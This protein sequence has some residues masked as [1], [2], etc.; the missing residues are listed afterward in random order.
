MQQGAAPI[1]TDVVVV[2]A[3]PVGL[4]QVFQL[5]LLEMRAEVVD[6]LPYVG[7]QCIELYADK[8]IYDIPGLPYCTGR[9]L[10]QRLQQ[11]ITP[12]KTTFHLGQE[13]RELRE[14]DTAD[15][16]TGG[17]RFALSTSQG[18]QFRCKAVIVAGGV[19]SFQ[20]RGLK[21]PGLEPFSGTQMRYDAH[22]TAALAGQHVVVAGDGDVAVDLALQLAQQTHDGPASV[23]LLHRRAELGASAERIA[24]VHAFCAAGRLRFEVGQP[25]GVE[26]AAGRLTHLQLAGADG[27]TRALPLDM[28]LVQLG[29][30]PRLGPIADW[31]LGL[32]QR[33]VVVDTERFQTS[34]PGIFAVGDINTYPG[35]KKLI[36]CGFHEATLAAFGAARLVFPDERKPLQYTT[37]SPRLHKLLGVQADASDRS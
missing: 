3:G 7:G 18:T 26:V 21:L 24:Q 15:A 16:P 22:D 30:S 29:L 11:Q 23:T 1:E 8:P 4:F 2:G 19:G 25:I 17:P 12:F 20:P 31:G 6:T 34:V 28:L 36:L 5:G 27:G 32:V 14:I 10:V 13:V 9:D 37:T 33:Q 35:K